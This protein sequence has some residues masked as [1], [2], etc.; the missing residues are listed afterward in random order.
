MAVAAATTSTSTELAVLD[1][2]ILGFGLDLW[3]VLKWVGW[4]A[5]WFA[6]AAVVSIACVVAYVALAE[7]RRRQ[8]AL[9]RR[10]RQ[11]RLRRR[12]LARMTSTVRDAPYE[13][14]VAARI[15]L[16]NDPCVVCRTE[17]EAG[18]TCSLL[19]RCAHVFHRHCIAAWLRH[20]D[21]CPICNAPLLTSTTGHHTS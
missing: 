8:A 10:K 21:T 17:Y 19:P 18:E 6:A 9:A 1:P 13:R 2:S 4:G 14:M 16:G 12:Q 15:F 20:H 5:L 3:R 7:L 11:Q